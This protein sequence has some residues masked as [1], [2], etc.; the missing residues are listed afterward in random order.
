ML[1]EEPARGGRP[2]QPHHEP[3]GASGR[4]RAPLDGALGA[5]LGLEHVQQLI[6]AR[7]KPA[8]AKDMGERLKEAGTTVCTLHGAPELRSFTS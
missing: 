8:K 2:P 1:Q 4:P 5:Q 3:D 7:V 6:G